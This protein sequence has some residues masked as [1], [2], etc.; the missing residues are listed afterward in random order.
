MQ[1]QTERVAGGVEQHAQIRSRLILR[2]P[3]SGG[4]S[5]RY[6]RLE[7]RDLDVEVNHLVLFAGTLRPHRRSIPLP[8]LER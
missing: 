3:G 2:E 4:Q 8:L 1:K 5:V 7:V 6:R